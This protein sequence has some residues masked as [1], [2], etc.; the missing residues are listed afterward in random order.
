MGRSKLS[1]TI[2]KHHAMKA[3]EDVGANLHKFLTSI[4]DVRVCTA[5]RAD[6][7]NP[8]ERIRYLLNRNLVEL[9]KTNIS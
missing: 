7:F 1:Q 3:Y 8:E 5:S 9:M 4:L 2:I 6:C